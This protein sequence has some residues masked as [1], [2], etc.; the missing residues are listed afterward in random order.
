[1]ELFLVLMMRSMMMM[2]MMMRSM[3]MRSMMMRS[4]MMWWMM[5]R[6]MRRRLH[7]IKESFFDPMHPWMFHIFPLFP[8]RLFFLSLTF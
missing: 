8:R 3:M 5:I 4:M 1:M 2:S 6:M 7:S